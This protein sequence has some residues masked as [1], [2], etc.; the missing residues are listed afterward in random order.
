M[1]IRKAD[2]RSNW[3]TKLIIDMCTLCVKHS[4]LLILSERA[5]VD[6]VFH[7]LMDDETQPTTEA[8]NS[9]HRVHATLVAA[10]RFAGKTEDID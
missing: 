2:I 3:R 9:L 4:D 1:K 6:S 7:K 8:F 10:L 5:L